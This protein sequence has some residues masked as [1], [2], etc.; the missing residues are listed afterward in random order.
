MVS[1]ER[2][3]FAD[4]SKVD[5]KNTSKLSIDYTKNTVTEEIGSRPNDPI[6][7]ETLFSKEGYKQVTLAEK[8]HDDYFN[9]KDWKDHVGSTTKFRVGDDI[10]SN[11]V[12]DTAK[13]EKLYKDE[14]GKRVEVTNPSQQVKEILG[15]LK[16]NFA[17][18]EIE[19]PLEK[20]RECK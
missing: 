16:I 6:R 2:E 3:S 4:A 11:E 5:T 18:L 9:W 13:T 12:D 14:R 20:E 17:K 7:S 15:D 19:Q 8:S 10:Y 1:H